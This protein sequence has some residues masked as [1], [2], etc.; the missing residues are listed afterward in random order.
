M[1]T[2]GS[3]I[4]PLSPRCQGAICNFIKEVWSILKRGNLIHCN[5][6]CDACP[7]YSLP[8][9]W[10]TAANSL[11]RWREASQT[12]AFVI[13]DWICRTRLWGMLR[14]SRTIVC[15]DPSVTHCR[16]SQNKNILSCSRSSAQLCWIT[17][18]HYNQSHLPT[19]TQQVY[20]V[21]MGFV[22]RG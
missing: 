19:P 1:L 10:R 4:T 14:H 17:F 18:T 20:I 2:E 11:Q 5:P 16:H 15:G 9:Q 13:R 6:C 12:S 3:E 21:E 22:T 7:A 8:Q